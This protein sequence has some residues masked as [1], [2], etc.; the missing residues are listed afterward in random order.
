MANPN[1]NLINCA[2][3]G[4][5]VSR[6]IPA[7]GGA[8]GEE[9]ARSS[10]WNMYA[11]SPSLDIYTD[12]SRVRREGP[13]WEADGLGFLFLVLAAVGLHCC[14][15]AFSSCGVRASHYSDFSYCRTQ[16]LDSCGT[17]V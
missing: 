8:G 12:R 2:A 16:A 7:L 14:A 17:E 6:N 3:A 9:M 13:A 5:E 10:I 4:S 11:L 1:N 15:R